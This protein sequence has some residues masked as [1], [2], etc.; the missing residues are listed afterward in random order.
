MPLTF[1][2]SQ[3]SSNWKLSEASE[4]IVIFKPVETS[5]PS[6][7][8]CFVPRTDNPEKAMALLKGKGLPLNG[9]D[10]IFQKEIKP[11]DYLSF[12]AQM[13]EIVSMDL[14]GFDL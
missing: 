10:L 11:K 14:E 9:Q 3:T 8:I 2:L 12:A 13:H 5:D 6:A 7:A 4:K 1:L